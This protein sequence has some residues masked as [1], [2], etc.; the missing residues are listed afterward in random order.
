[1]KS[2]FNLKFSISFYNDLDNITSYIK[3]KLNNIIA[4]DNLIKKVEKE[5]ENRVKNPLAYERYKTKEGNI[6]YRIYI[7]NYMVFYTV[8]ENTMEIRRII[9]NKRDLEKL[10]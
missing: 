7:K 3:Y 4:A 9:Y 6:Y 8:C 5:I 2:K 10:I 1:M